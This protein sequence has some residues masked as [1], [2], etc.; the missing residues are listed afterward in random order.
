[1]SEGKIILVISAKSKNPPI[2]EISNI[3]IPLCV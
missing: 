1:M 2:T 3:A